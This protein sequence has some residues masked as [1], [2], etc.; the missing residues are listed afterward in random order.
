ML[1]FRSGWR[2]RMSDRKAPC[3]PRA[4][5]AGDVGWDGAPAA[6]ARMDVRQENTARA[7]AAGDDA[8]QVAHA[9]DLAEPLDFLAWMPPKFLR[10]HA[11]RI[12]ARRRWRRLIL[13]AAAGLLLYGFVLAPGGLIS[14]LSRRHRIGELQHQI[15]VL[16]R[17]EAW[18]QA[19][20][21][22]RKSDAPTI[23]RIAREEYG[24]VY[25]GETVYR[26]R[27]V[28]EATARR[29]ESAQV[30]NAQPEA[31]DRTP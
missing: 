21:E 29:I 13:A 18:L 28:D 14:I 9:P 31:E 8:A 12:A 7:H 11:E 4:G 10:R 5:A 17:R 16:Q 20:I 24:L 6:T 1:D 2:K 19:E 30:A 22:R 25:P 27:E 15:D 3:G 23:E 26:I